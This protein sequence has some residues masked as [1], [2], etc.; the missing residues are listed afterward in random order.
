M[1]KEIKCLELPEYDDNAVADY[2]GKPSGQQDNDDIIFNHVAF[3][4]RS[5]KEEVNVILYLF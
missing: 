5:S 1:N 3:T 4:L 2:A